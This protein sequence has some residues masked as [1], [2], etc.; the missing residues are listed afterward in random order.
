MDTTAL[1]ASPTRRPGARWTRA[2]LDLLIVACLAYGAVRFVSAGVLP[3]LTALTGDFGASFPSDQAA[4]LR[5]DFP[6]DAPRR[7][8]TSPV[9]LAHVIGEWNYGPVFH[10]LSLPLLLAPTWAAVPKLWAATNFVTLAISFVLVCRLIGRGV[11][12]SG[13]ALAVLAAM[14]LCYQPLINCYR[15]GDIEIIEMVLILCAFGLLA[16]GRDVAS[17][18]LLG[19]ATMTKFLPVG[20]LAW[21]AIRFRMRAV[22]AGVV[23][24][25]VIAAATSATLEWRNSISLRALT[26]GTGQH[27]FVG[28][29]ELSLTSALVHWVMPTDW[30]LGGPVFRTSPESQRRAVTAGLVLSAA[31]G[32]GYLLFY[33]V[34]RRAPVT[35]LDPAILLLLLVLLPPWNHDYYYIFALVAVSVLFL[36]SLSTGRRGLLAAALVAYCMISPPLPFGVFDRTGWFPGRFVYVLNLSGLPVLG[37]LLLLGAATRARF[38]E[39]RAALSSLAAVASA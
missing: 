7:A 4:R 5:P 29:H 23:T 31:I 2:L 21:L 6:T 15:Q 32:L 16:K 37:A 25:V 12:V 10:A 11:S 17:G 19:V 30:V 18:A 27:P 8:I 36:M 9:T 35:A 28:P 13:R 24:I 14:W 38:R 22:F 20:F 39:A 26:D 34:L 33:V 3:A 1:I